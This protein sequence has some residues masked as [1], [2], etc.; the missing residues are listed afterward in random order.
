MSG[1]ISIISIVIG[2]CASIMLLIIKSCI[3]QYL[4]YHRICSDIKMQMFLV[5]SREALSKYSE[6][7]SRIMDIMSINDMNTKRLDKTR[8]LKEFVKTHCIYF[9]KEV[10][11]IFLE[12]SLESLINNRLEPILGLLEKQFPRKPP[13]EGVV[14]ILENIIEKLSRSKTRP[15]GA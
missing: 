1:E 11:A 13:P 4:S 2:F 8:E 5:H 6:F 3:D 9:P 12:S 14:K 10:T 7:M 15:E